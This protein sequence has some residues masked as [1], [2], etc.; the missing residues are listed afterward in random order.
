MHYART[1]KIARFFV[2]RMPK[3]NVK[4]GFWEVFRVFSTRA[5]RV[6]KEKNSRI[7]TNAG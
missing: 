2:A 4:M 1:V 6:V 3:E 7:E 5:G